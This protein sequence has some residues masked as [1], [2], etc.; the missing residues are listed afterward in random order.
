M[1]SD[2]FCFWFQ[3]NNW[4]F[5]LSTFFFIW[6]Q[7]RSSQTKFLAAQSHPLPA[8][9]VFRC[10]TQHK[11]FVRLDKIK[12]RKGNRT[13]ALNVLKYFLPQ[14]MEIYCWLEGGP[15]SIGNPI[16]ATR[17]GMGIQITFKGL[18]IW[19]AAQS[20]VTAQWNARPVKQLESRMVRRLSVA[21]SGSDYHSLPKLCSVFYNSKPKGVWDLFK[22][23]RKNCQIWFW[24][25]FRDSEKADW[26]REFLPVWLLDV[27][28]FFTTC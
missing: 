12:T 17:V 9:S 16:T 10:R 18:L 3:S 11:A 19:L 25:V 23:L 27:K 14:F 8:P 7:S 1:F 2:C 26:W 13:N 21:M 6:D 24:K 5:K 4:L 22:K 20:C 15:M 28:N